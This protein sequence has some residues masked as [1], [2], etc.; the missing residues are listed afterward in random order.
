MPS[1]ETAAGGTIKCTARQ[2]Q[3]DRPPQ[4]LLSSF[5]LYVNA[6]AK[7]QKKYGKCKFLGEFF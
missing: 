7:I 1:S 4:S 2:S 3:V 6:T 5:L